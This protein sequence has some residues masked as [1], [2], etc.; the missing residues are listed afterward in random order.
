MARHA[1]LGFPVEH[2]LAGTD[3]PYTLSN[4]IELAEQAVDSPRNSGCFS[5]PQML[6]VETEFALALFPRVQR[7]FAKAFGEDTTR[8]ARTAGPSEKCPVVP[9]QF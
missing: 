6:G 5:E 9:L 2:V 1:G 7:E 3:W 8:T 4:S